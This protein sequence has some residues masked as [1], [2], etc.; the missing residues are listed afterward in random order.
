[1]EENKII[2]EDEKEENDI[3]MNCNDLNEE[4][5]I[6]AKENGFILLG[7]TGV[8]K[9]SLLNII[10]GKDIGKVGYSSNSETY[11]TTC[12]YKMEI[13]ENNK[14]YFT[15]ID[16]PGLYDTN[17]LDNDLEQKKDMLKLISTKKI[18]IKSIFFLSNFQNE[19]FDASEQ[20][21]LIEY[22]S[23]FPLKDF[24]KRIILIFTHCY[25]DP[26]GDSFE[27]IQKRSSDSFNNII[28][29]IMKKVKDVSKPINFH[30]IIKKYYNIYS[31]H[32]NEKQI[33]NNENIKNDIILD[34]SKF[35]GLPPLYN[36][37][38]SF[39]FEKYKI[40]EKDENIYD[41]IFMR[42]L[43]FNDNIIYEDLI[44]IKK[45]SKKNYSQ[46]NS[47]IKYYTENCTI[48]KE[49]NLCNKKI[50]LKD[51]KSYLGIGLST[52]SIVSGIAFPSSSLI[53][54]ITGVIGIYL[55]KKTKDEKKKEKE[56]INEKIKEIKNN[57]KIY[58][59][60]FENNKE[61]NKETIEKKNLEDWEILDK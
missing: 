22:N 15:I 34:I 19:R 32:K 42:Y 57:E 61:S 24:W 36:K 39:Q 48:S 31:K 9:T 5:L 4:E 45:Y 28:N 41:F 20:S 13:I 27:E 35:C 8:G 44:D 52:L 14:Y 55:I 16:T 18:K 30:D 7:K 58:E 10:L 47:K 11:K 37:L 56:E 59:K 40:D 3:E 49:G 21:T 46:K 1:M 25:G 50:H 33:K 6:K 29:K 17:G 23:L 43:D 38:E 53:S 54:C 2:F 12:Y 51:K 60:I 26:D